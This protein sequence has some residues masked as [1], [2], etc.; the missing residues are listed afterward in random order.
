MCVAYSSLLVQFFPTDLEEAERK[1][2]VN[3]L[4]S[5]TQT[6]D[7][8]D[9]LL[10]ADLAEKEFVAEKQN[11]VILTSQS[12]TGMAAGRHTLSLFGHGEVING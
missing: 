11:V 10:Q 12:Y 3:K 1:A 4:N 9:F 7:L 2:Q 5:L 8:G 6:D